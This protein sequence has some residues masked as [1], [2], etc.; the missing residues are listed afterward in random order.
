VLDPADPATQEIDA[1]NKRIRSDPHVDNVL[2]PLRDG[3]MLV[4]KL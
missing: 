4:F 3:I 2:L 1:L